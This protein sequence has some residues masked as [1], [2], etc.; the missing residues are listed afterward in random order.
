MSAGGEGGRTRTKCSDDIIDCSKQLDKCQ[1]GKWFDVLSA[2]CAGSCGLCTRQEC[3]DFRTD[4]RQ[5]KALCLAP[6]SID[7]MRQQCARTCGFC[8]VGAS[9]VSQGGC[10]GMLGTRT[11]FQ[12][13]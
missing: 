11:C 13:R 7:D 12:S 3:R 5:R 6:D 10:W 8:V 1:M 4:C 9:G 2:F